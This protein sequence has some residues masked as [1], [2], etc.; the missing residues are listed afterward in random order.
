MTNKTMPRD[1]IRGAI[2][3]FLERFQENLGINVLEVGSRIHDPKAWWINNKDLKLPNA[4][5]LGVDIQEGEGVDLVV[6]SENLPKDW[7]E[8]FTGVLCS[9]VLEHTPHPQK[10]IDEL[11]RVLKPGGYL[12][13]TTLLTH[14]IHGY[15]NDYWRFTSEG[16][17]HLC[18]T[19]GFKQDLLYLEYGVSVDI[20]YKVQDERLARRTI[21]MQIFALA[22][23]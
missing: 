9:E 6:D 2:R 10:M 1:S 8:K 23:K 18:L 4:T 11:Y 19:S 22:K 12:V 3:E 13:L 21:P 16:I 7:S 17:K 20:A 14:P 15:P 5:W